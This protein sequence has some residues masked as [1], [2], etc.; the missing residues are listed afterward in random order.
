MGLIKSAMGIGGLL[1]EGIGD[2]LRL[3]DRQRRRD[4]R[5]LRHSA[6]GGLSVAGPEV[7]SCPTCG[8]TNIDVAKIASEVGGG[9]PARLRQARES[10]C[11]GLHRERPGRGQRRRHRHRGRQ[12]LRHA[13]RGKGR[14]VRMLQGDIVGQL[15]E[16]IERLV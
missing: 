15:C 5:G 7:V 8:R 6:R 4:P 11:D 2:T 10:G 13:V 14:Q 9:A 1:M 16:E 3:A 12:G